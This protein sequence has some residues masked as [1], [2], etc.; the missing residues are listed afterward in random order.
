[1]LRAVAKSRATTI[2]LLCQQTRI[3]FRLAVAS[4]VP[5]T[6]ELLPAKWDEL[7]LAQ[8]LL[9]SLPEGSVVVADK[10][11]ISDK[12]QQLSYINGRVRLVPK[13]RRNMRD[14]PVKD[15]ML[16]RAHH[17]HIEAVNGQLEKTG[18]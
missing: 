15:I 8:D 18:L 1:M 4:G 17:S 12:D 3:L 5:V 11:Y 7:T 16:I 6:F 10:G 9:R 13:Q 2:W 14:N